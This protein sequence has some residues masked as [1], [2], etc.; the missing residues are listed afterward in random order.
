MN[1]P[2]EPTWQDAETEVLRWGVWEYREAVA[3]AK[4]AGVHPVYVLACVEFYKEHRQQLRLGP[5]D[6]LR[7]IQRS[8]K[9][10]D[11]DDAKTFLM[12]R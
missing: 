1:A 9:Y 10:L 8:A 12:R 2:T 3:A 4:H 6:L 11:P 7:R 5:A